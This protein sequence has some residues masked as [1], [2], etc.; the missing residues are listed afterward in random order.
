MAYHYRMRC[1]AQTVR[2]YT[3]SEDA[4]CGSFCALDACC[5]MVSATIAESS[6]FATLESQVYVLLESVVTMQ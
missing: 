6:T 4:V 3:S 1:A 2:G 5:A